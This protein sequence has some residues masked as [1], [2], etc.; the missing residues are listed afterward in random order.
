[1]HKD[2][3]FRF[4]AN[5]PLNIRRE[6]ILTLK[7]RGPITWEVAYLEIQSGSDLGEEILKKL[8][9]FKFIPIY[10]EDTATE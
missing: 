10:G 8:V 5:L 6:V 2:A 1:M 4:Y 9:E 3:F 7:D